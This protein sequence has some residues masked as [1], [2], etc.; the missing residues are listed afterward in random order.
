MLREIIKRLPKQK[1]NRL[2]AVKMNRIS[3]LEIHVA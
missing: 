2:M 3:G 1:D